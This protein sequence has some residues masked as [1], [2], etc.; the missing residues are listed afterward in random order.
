M[1]NPAEAGARA[2]AEKL[3]AR[4]G[5]RLVSEVEQILADQGSETPPDQ[6][7]DP[8]AVASVIVSAATLAWTVYSGLRSKK[9]ATTPKVIVQNVI[10]QIREDHTS[11]EPED[12]EI[13][14]IAVQETLKAIDGT[15]E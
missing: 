7:L 1:S 4:Y 13:I 15:A 12:E 3:K 2:A 11:D 5:S 14:A 6:Y 8:T 9:E 10:V